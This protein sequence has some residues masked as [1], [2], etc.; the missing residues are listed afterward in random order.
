MPPLSSSK[1]LCIL[2]VTSYFPG[3]DGKLIFIAD[4]AL[5]VIDVRRAHFVSWARRDIVV[6][7]PAQLRKDGEDLVGFLEKAMYGT[8]DAAACWAAEV[9]RVFVTVLGFTQGRANPCHFFHADNALRFTATTLKRSLR[10]TS[11]SG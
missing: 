10:T 9:V 1:F 4:P 3:Q 7:F 2:A 6:E 8:R 11:L 5:I